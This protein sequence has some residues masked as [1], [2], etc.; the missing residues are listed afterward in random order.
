MID[1][2]CIQSPCIPLPVAGLHP[3][4]R[5]PAGAGRAWPSGN[6]IARCAGNRGSA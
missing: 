3:V 4:A 2:Y 6:A 5:D 1:R